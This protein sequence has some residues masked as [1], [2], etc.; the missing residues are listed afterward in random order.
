MATQQNQTLLGALGGVGT[1][2]LELLG[3]KTP[4]VE[5]SGGTT[6]TASPVWTPPAG[7]GFQAAGYRQGADGTFY[8]LDQAG[9]ATPFVPN[10][11][12][13]AQL[14]DAGMPLAS[15]TVETA[16]AEG[17]KKKNV[18]GSDDNVKTANAL[19]SVLAQAQANKPKIGQAPAAT[20]GSAI[21]PNTQLRD[22][23]ATFKPR[24]G[25]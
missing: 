3:L 4:G 12:Q 24:R 6:S 5:V 18:L 2:I 15:T 11:T 7:R 10:D 14:R 9:N 16:Q 13:L 8:R 21:N 17:E 1:N 20:A 23:F 22:L 25:A 19:A